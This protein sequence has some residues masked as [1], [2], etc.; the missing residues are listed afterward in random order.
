MTI[1]AKGTF[2]V[3]LTPQTQ[4]GEFDHPGLAR[5]SLAKEFQGDLE[6]TSR[7]QMMSARTAL[8]NSA[9]YVA[10]ERVSGTLNGR[11]GTFVLQHSATMQR[12]V[13]QQSITVVPDSGTGELVGLEGRMT[14]I[15]SN[16]QHFYEFDYALLEAR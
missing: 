2:Q 8:E 9:G 10:L 12:G 5:L 7:G 4:D 6:G 16:G 1:R 11:A 14:I 13:P 3:K 15:I